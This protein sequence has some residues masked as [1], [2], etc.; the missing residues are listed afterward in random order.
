M[1]TLAGRIKEGV[2]R[3]RDAISEDREKYQA[4]AAIAGGVLLT[5]TILSAYTATVKANQTQMAR[6]AVTAAGS[7]L[8]QTPYLT[9]GN[10]GATGEI[11]FSEGVTSWIP[12]GMIFIIVMF[13]L[14]KD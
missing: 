4:G 1:G 6:E 5:P 3:I 2:D 12:I 14:F 13:V 8:A 10:I 9:S 7:Q 11:A